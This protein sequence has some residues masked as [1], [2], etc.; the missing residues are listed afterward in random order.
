MERKN[1]SKMLTMNNRKIGTLLR[2]PVATDI[3]GPEPTVK[4]YSA[5]TGFLRKFVL[6]KYT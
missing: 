1:Y 6:L 4:V 5:V 3:P 2:I